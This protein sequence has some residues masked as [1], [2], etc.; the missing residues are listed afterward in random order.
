MK[1]VRFH[2]QKDIRLEEVEEPECGRGQIKIKPAFCGI[3]GTDLHEYLGGA[4]LIPKDTP[5]PIT[6]ETLPLA[7]GHEFSGIVEEVGD[8]VQGFK[9]G[10]RVCVQPTIYDGECLSCRRGLVNCCDKN[11]FVGLSG[12]G[13]GMSEH[14][15]LP[16]DSVKKLPDNISLEVGALVEPLAVA[17]H[18]LS[19]SPYKPGDRV[20]VLGGGP[21][22]LAVVQV[23]KARG[24]D[25]IILSEISPRRRQYAKEF[26][27]HHVIDP[28]K[29][30]VVA[31]VTKLTHGEGVEIA[32][33]AAGVQ[34]GV[35]SA[36]LVIKA[37]GTLVNI[38]VWEKRAT[39]NI[40]QLV[41]RERAYIGTACY[42]LGD[43]ELVIDA[44][45]TGKLTPEAMITRKIKLDE[46]EEKGFNALIN[47]KDNHVKILV[48][49]GASTSQ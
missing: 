31:E 4:N 23:L 36:M 10:D 40:N 14:I 38:A 2:G 15:V 19:I 5:H 9:A 45:S 20:L 8:E 13:G 44:I 32:F 42:A 24:C 37:R 6:N 34:V 27:A 29:D 16:Q 43:F 22:G 39:L 7:L 26:G 46:V 28:T 1:A 30:D 49:I 48:D 33:D 25:S 21:I 3:C 17:W 41:F 11:G 12:W 47:D 18:A 35:D